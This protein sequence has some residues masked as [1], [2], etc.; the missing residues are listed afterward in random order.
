MGADVDNISS[1]ISYSSIA[2]LG[3]KVALEET[4]TVAVLSSDCRLGSSIR[5][6]CVGMACEESD[7]DEDDVDPSVK[8][9]SHSFQLDGGCAERRLLRRADVWTDW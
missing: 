2:V 8:M 9:E 1:V 7:D 5:R 3:A 6:E 4:N